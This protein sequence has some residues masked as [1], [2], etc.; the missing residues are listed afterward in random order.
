MKGCYDGGIVGWQDGRIV[1][2]WESSSYIVGVIN[3]D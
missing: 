2:Q 3:T 1:R